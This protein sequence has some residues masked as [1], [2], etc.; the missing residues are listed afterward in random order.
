MTPQNKLKKTPKRPPRATKRKGG[1]V[2][3][4]RRELIEE[5]KKM[6]VLELSELIK[7]LEEEFGV[8]ATAVAAAA[9][10]AAGAGDGAAAEEESSTV[11]VVLTGAGDKKIQVIKVVRAA[12]GL[13]LKEAKAVV[14]EAPKPVKEGLERDEAEKLKA[15][16]RG[17]RRQRRA[18]V[19]SRP[20]PATTSTARSPWSPGAARGI[21]FETARRMHERGASVTLTDLDQEATERAAA[22]IGD[23]TLPLAA[24]AADGGRMEEVVEATVERFGGL[25]VP[26]ANAGVAPPGA[27]MRVVDPDAF[28]R[29]IEI[30]L[31][32]V[33]RTVRPT[34]PQVVERGGHV[35]VV[36]SVMAWVNGVGGSSSRQSPGHRARDRLRDRPR[37]TSAAPRS[38]C[39]TSTRR[40]PSRPRRGRRAD[41]RHGRRRHRRRAH[42]GGRPGDGR[43][44]RRAR[45]PDRQ[46]RRRPARRHDARRRPRRLRARDRD[47][48]ARR[49]AHGAPGAAAGRRARRVRSS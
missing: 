47:R 38:P 10:A 9:P 23:R 43:A 40:R 6:S 19:G 34:L 31:L 33:W 39:S 30:D 12:T 27:T 36:S 13:G 28:E 45:H 21:G 24:D 7:A 29:V 18:E 41:A 46:R 35:V 26:V 2:H 48:P 4:Y 1:R 3:G 22:Q 16:A 5:I 8:S 15:R 42:G 49:L 20:W 37:S 17:G 25:D 11:D 44:L 14:D 32:G